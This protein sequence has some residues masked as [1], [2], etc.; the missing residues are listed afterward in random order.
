M[1]PAEAGIFQFYRKTGGS[2]EL[3]GTYKTY[4]GGL[5]AT[6]LEILDED[7][8]ISF[9]GKEK[10]REEGTYLRYCVSSSR[11]VLDDVLY[12]FSG[13]EPSGRPLEIMVEEKECMKLAR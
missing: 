7:C 11:N 10:L 3:T 5:R 12:H 4:Y 6:F 9:P 13:T 8:Q 1:I 2:L